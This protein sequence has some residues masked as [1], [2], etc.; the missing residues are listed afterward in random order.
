MK[1]KFFIGLKLK[2]ADSFLKTHK[3]ISTKLPI[4]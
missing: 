3:I 1:T 4:R 2:L